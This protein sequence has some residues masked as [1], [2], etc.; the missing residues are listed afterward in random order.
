MVT[1]DEAQRYLVGMHAHL[2]KR[3]KSHKELEDFYRGKQPLEMAS[4]EFTRFFSDRYAGF[5]DNWTQVVADA[6]TERLEVTGIKLPGVKQEADTELWEDWRRSEADH[7]ADTAFLE[8]VISRRGFASVWAN[9]DGEPT[10]S[11]ETPRQMIIWYDPETGARTAS[12]KVWQDGSY[13]YATLK[14]PDEIYKFQRRQQ[15]DA[16]SD[17]VGIILPVNSTMG[18]AGWEPRVPRGEPWPLPNPLGLVPDVEIQNRPRLG[19]K[20]MSDVAG[21]VAM[22]KAVNLMWSYLLNAADFAS[23]PQRVIM[24]NDRPMTP[25]LDDN[26]K[27]I[28]SKVVPLEKFSVERVVWLEN[29]NAK[30]GEWTAANLE[31]Y[32]RVIE[33]QVGH[34][35]AQTRTPQHYLIGKMANLSG[36]AL[37]AAETGLVKR[38]E[39]K[40]KSFG[41]GIREVFRL[42]ALV[43]G[44]KAKADAVR[45]GTV[46]WANVA[47]RSEAQLADAAQKWKAAGFPIEWIARRIGMSPTE[48]TDL[49]ESL[50][51]QAARDPVARFVEATERPVVEES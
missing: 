11:F 46:V 29:P 45:L 20:P 21:V 2:M 4:P 22:Q 12:L 42:V 30:I 6:P 33:V 25:V 24:G 51:A 28:G 31:L 41:R 18:A 10:I 1:Q 13:E 40:T 34:I 9:Q 19:A 15:G 23:F 37:L 44:E 8:A 16:S 47:Q 27:V 43:R 14:F 3:R 36:D 17:V 7:G 39:E 32:T 35:A 49:V 26:G 38:T 48:I 5:A 50:D